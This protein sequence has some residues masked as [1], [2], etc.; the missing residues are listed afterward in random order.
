M[1]TEKRRVPFRPPSTTGTHL[2]GLQEDLCH[3]HCWICW[4]RSVAISSAVRS[5][6]RWRPRLQTC[7]KAGKHPTIHFHHRSSIHLESKCRYAYSSP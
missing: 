1:R 4:C 5:K 7:S 2:H 3:L 6:S